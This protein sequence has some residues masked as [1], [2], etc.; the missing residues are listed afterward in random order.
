M[1]E[2]PEVPRLGALVPPPRFV[3]GHEIIE[4]SAVSFMS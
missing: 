3:A 4:T 1:R 2:T